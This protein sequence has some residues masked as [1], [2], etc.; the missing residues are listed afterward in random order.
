MI[1]TFLSFAAFP[2][3][4]VAAPNLALLVV[5]FMIGG[6]REIGEPSRKAMI[7]DFAQEGLRARSVG[8]YYLVR[9]LS[10][11]PAAAIGG[12]LGPLLRQIAVAE[13]TPPRLS[14]EDVRL[15]GHAIECRLNAEDWTRDFRPSP[16]TVTS[17]IFPAGEGIRIDTH[18]Q[19]GAQ[20][21]PY[22]DSL[23]AKLIVHG[24]D[25]SAAIERMRGALSRCELGGLVTNLP[26]HAELMAQ[27]EFAAGGFTTAYFPRF[28]DRKI[29]AGGFNG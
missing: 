29:A 16:G 12:A 3:A 1:L 18:M 7:V 21:P 27:E 9:S 23:V 26:M 13:G 14:K 20:V 6:L 4:I 5:A 28:L 22:Y 2:L 8:L 25:R 11:T 24:S 15:S 10:I 17:A 19:A